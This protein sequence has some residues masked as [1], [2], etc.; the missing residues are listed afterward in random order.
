MWCARNAEGGCG[1]V[2]KSRTPVSKQELAQQDQ[3]K[4]AGMQG[5]TQ[6]NDEAWEQAL[7]RWCREAESEV[8]LLARA[9]AQPALP[10]VEEIPWGDGHANR[11]D[12]QVSPG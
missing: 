10:T 3:Q 9:T 2:Q 1:N 7:E 11:R 8:R 5:P 4:Q 12:V 6:R